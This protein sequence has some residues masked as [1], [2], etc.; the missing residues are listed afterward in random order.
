MTLTYC[1]CIDRDA[2]RARSP[3]LAQQ[4]SEPGIRMSGLE[5]VTLARRLTG[6]GN[7]KPTLQRHCGR[8]K[9]NIHE[10]KS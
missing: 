10:S 7:P 9:A 6:V 2:N 1:P 3:R 4:S 8:S 5:D